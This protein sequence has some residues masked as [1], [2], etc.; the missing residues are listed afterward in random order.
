[1]MAYSAHLEV[2]TSADAKQRRA[3]IRGALHV[4]VAVEDLKMEMLPVVDEIQD[5][6]EVRSLVVGVF[7]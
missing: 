3:K 7:R 2:I 4:N 1:M 5:T 6:A